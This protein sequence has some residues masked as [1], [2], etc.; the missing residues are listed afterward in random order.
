VRAVSERIRRAR[1][2]SVLVRRVMT[3]LGAIVSTH[4]SIVVSRRRGG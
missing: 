1:K 2:G 4:H 3:V